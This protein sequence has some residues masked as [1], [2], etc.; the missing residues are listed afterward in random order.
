MVECN[1][2][3]SRGRACPSCNAQMMSSDNF[4]SNCGKSLRTVPPGKSVSKQIIVYLVSFFL[5][6]L[7]LYYAWKYLNQD[8]RTSK[9]IGVA[10]IALTIASIAIALWTASRLFNL[11]SQYFD[12][13]PGLGF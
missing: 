6:P 8:D 7:G 11:L 9:I 10:A 4:C 1:M 12:L 3:I 2:E 5:A 13:S